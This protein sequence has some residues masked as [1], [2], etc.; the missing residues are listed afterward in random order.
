M[1]TLIFFIN[2][3]NFRSMKKVTVLVSM[4][5]ILAV[6]GYSQVAINTDGSNSNSSAM[7]DVKSTDKG[8]LI[9]RMTQTQIEV[10]ASPANGLI[11]YNTDDC[12]FY[13]YRD[14]SSNWVEIADGT[15]TITPGGGSFTCGDAL[16]DSRDGQSYNTVLIGTQC[17]MA[18]NLNIGTMINGSNDQTD[19]GTIE[20]YC[21]NNS[22]SNCDTYG[23]LYQWDEAMQYVTTA[24]TQ[25]VCPA[26]WHI[27]TDAEWMTMEEYLGMCSGTGSG[28]S[29]AT[30]W[31]G[32]D[33]GGKLKETGTTHW[34]SPNTGATNSSG[35]TALPGGYR[36]TDGSFHN[37]TSSASFWLS[38]E[39]GSNAWYRYLHYNSAQVIRG[40]NNKAYGFSVRC[41]RD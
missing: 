28:C 2:N 21:Y 7:L 13:A 31:R 1:E 5:L 29:G 11:V 27:P 22:T 9:P 30:G 39:G 36:Y 41:V 4:L 32:T 3:L 10:I 6:S 37:L 16:V 14:C 18:E 19:N 12:K 40:Y 8:M 17:W 15:G 24:G 25:G 20:K 26:G 23:G 34:T 38:T 35:F 33:E